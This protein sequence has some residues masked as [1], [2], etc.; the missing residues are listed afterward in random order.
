MDYGEDVM[1]RSV[2]RSRKRTSHE[3]HLMMMWCTCGAWAPVWFMAWIWNALGPKRKT[4]TRY[5]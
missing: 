2:S 3:F 1:R 4:V 5:R